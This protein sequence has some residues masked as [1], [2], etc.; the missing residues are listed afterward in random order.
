MFMGFRCALL[1]TGLAGAL[2]LEASAQIDA[3]LFG[4]RLGPAI[5]DAPD[6]GDEWIV[7]EEPPAPPSPPPKAE[8]SSETAVPTP[9]VFPPKQEGTLPE[10]TSKGDEPAPTKR[11]RSWLPWR[12]KQ[13]EREERLALEREKVAP[14][15][16]DVRTGAS[17]VSGGVDSGL[18]PSELRRWKRDPRKA[19]A[20]AREDRKLLLLWM[21]DSL[22][23]STSKEQAIEVFRHTQFLRMAKDYMVLTKIDYAE[24]DIASH[25][26]ARHLR[27]QLKVIGYPV[28]ILFSPDSKELWRSR[29]YRRGR[30]PQIIDELRYQVKTF[31]LKERDRH[32]KLVEKGFR[33]WNND[34]NQPIFAKAMEVSREDKTVLLLDEN[35]ERYRYPVV[36]LSEED[37][38]WLAER[39]LR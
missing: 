14:R 27:E 15:L 23:S 3:T 20:E 36:R 7:V 35:G 39:F 11:R 9:S 22:R 19:M 34:R 31:A 37:R 6:T 2:L 25:K 29:G 18:L 26:Y 32:E 12:N 8:R 24:S 33:T 16:G 1:V 38:G 30:F 13:R 4:D 10:A 28:L 17:Q 5:P 21:M